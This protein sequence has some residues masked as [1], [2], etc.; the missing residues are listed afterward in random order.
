VKTLPVDVALYRRL[1]D[2]L[3]LS[4]APMRFNPEAM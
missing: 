2:E 4:G 1:R 3:E